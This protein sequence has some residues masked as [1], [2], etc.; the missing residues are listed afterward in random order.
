VE[1]VAQ[2][3]VQCAQ[4]SARSTSPLAL[5]LC[6]P[7]VFTLK[8]LVQLAGAWSGAG[9]SRGRAVL[10][11]PHWAGYLQA[12][13]MECAPGAPLMSRDNLDSMKMDNI[14]TGRVPGLEHLGIT[15]ASMR[16]IG[17]G[18]PGAWYRLGGRVWRG[19][20]K[21]PHRAEL[22]LRPQ[23]QKV[24]PF[25]QL[26]QPSVAAMTCSLA[27]V[28]VMSRLRIVSWPMRSSGLKGASSTFSM[29]QALGCVGQVRAVGV[30]GA[31]SRCRG[32]VPASPRR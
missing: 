8:Q 17:T 28:S 20:S 18:V 11:L 21:L 16:A 13:L 25:A 19:G 32:A 23:L 7:E 12:L 5:E 26:Q 10:P 15:P 29:R 14:A 27:R 6:G 31:C 4:R 2:A 1:D 24:I 3:V 22:G 9:G 30:R